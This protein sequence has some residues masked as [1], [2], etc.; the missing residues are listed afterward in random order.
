MLARV[1]NQASKVAPRRSGAAVAAQ[2]STK[3][4]LVRNYSAAAS[5]PKV[6]FD[7]TIGGADA[8]RITFEVRHLLSLF[9]SNAHVHTLKFESPNFRKHVVSFL[10]HLTLPVA[11][12]PTIC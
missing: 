9:Y 1:C 6:F 3:A 7:V 12:L 5:N 4:K 10:Q 11:L 2:R 8:G